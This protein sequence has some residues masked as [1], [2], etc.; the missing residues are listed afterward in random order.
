MLGHR[1]D[2]QR[3]RI[4]VVLELLVQRPG[5]LLPQHLDHG[6]KRTVSR[7]LGD[8]NVKELVARERL[9]VRVELPLHDGDR[10]FDRRDLRLLRRF[11]GKRGA[12]ALDDVARAQQF[13][14][15]GGGVNG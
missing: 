4:V 15:S 6:D 7:R 5:A 10:V 12:L 8:A 14:R 1:R 9:R 13:E 2:P 3:R 11:R